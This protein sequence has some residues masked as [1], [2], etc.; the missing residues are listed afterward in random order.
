MSRSRCRARTI[1]GFSTLEVLVALTVG[2][3]VVTGVYKVLFSQSRLYST[4]QAAMD[5]RQSLRAAA[6]L[7]SWEIAASA[8]NAGDLYTVAP[9]SLAFRSLQ[10]TGVI[11]ANTFV[12]PKYRFGLQEATGYFEGT[13]D[14]S[15][16]VYTVDSGDWEVVK[17]ARAFNRAHS[18]DPAPSGGGTP[19][20][21]W[22]DS[23][24]SMPRPQATL[25]LDGD[26]TV[27]NH[28]VLG[29]P[30]RAFRR[31]QYGLMSQDGH[32]WLGRRIGDAVSAE[33]VTGPLLSPAQ[34]GLVFTYYDANGATTTDPA[35]VARV[36]FTLRGVSEK[37]GGPGKAPA[38]DS[39]SMS[40][41]IRG[42]RTQ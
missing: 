17:V 37:P 33:V 38:V 21:F 5:V 20:C 13:A 9:D 40:V 15:A 8:P 34:G 31:T 36:D 2:L 24:A 28:L 1:C 29:A 3:L 42:N 30:V 14:D 16:L 27:L 18:W 32:W 25:E 41:F 35:A 39:L 11:C 23:T 6:A 10:G 22:G 7:L 12:G 4:H 19:V 26:T